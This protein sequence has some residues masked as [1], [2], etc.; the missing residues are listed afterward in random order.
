MNT[1]ET[2]IKTALFSSSVFI[3]LLSLLLLG[4]RVGLAQTPTI[5]DTPAG[6]TLS[7]FLDAFNSGDHAKLDAY[8]KAYDSNETVEDLTRF[9]A[10]T[11][12]FNLLSIEH[13]DPAFISFRVKGRADKIEAFGTFQLD[14]TAPPKVRTW[15]IRAIPPGATVDNITLDAAA[16][17]TTIDA[18]AAKLTDF[19]IYPDVAQ[20]MIQSLRDHEKHGDYDTLTN[21]N[22]FASQLRKDLIAVSNDH[23]I[24]V[25]YNPFKMPPSPAHEDDKPHPPSP[26]DIAR[27]R[28][29]LEHDNCAFT[30]VEILPRNIGYIKFNQF[31]P[32]DLCGPTVNAALG[33]LAH[34]DA[35]IVDLRQNGGG[36]PAMVQYIASFFF[37]HPT[38]I[39]DLY[40]RHDDET[41]QYWTL[42]YVPGPRISAPLY[43]LT[44]SR[45]FSGAEEFTYDMQTQKRATIVGETTG[46]GAHPVNGMPAGD[47][48][49]IGVPLARPINPVT[50]KDW[51]GT[52]IT[53]DVKVPA[54]DALDTAQKLASEALQKK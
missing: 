28:T 41:K 3:C 1:Q 36:D 35:V 16:R 22:A 47:H 19:Y 25:S 53:P 43:V 2:S 12:G 34:T 15:T 5:P 6:K 26:E 33:F 23:H 44:S 31:A 39:N 46:G 50:K 29:E 37:D 45:T 7:A 13:S 11:G 10:Q 4:S 54:D 52:G 17:R 40:N 49:T 48:F 24:F 42:A 9:G 8:I 27:F 21:G 32:P 30:K 14:S 20:K 51:E 18:I 38:H